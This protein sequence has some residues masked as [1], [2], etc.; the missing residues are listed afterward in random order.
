MEKH[1]NKFK[2]AVKNYK[3]KT[4]NICNMDEKGFLMELASKAKVICRQGRRNSRYTCDGSRELITVLECVSAEKHLLPSMIVTK[5]AH[6]YSDNYVRGQGM[7]GSVYGHSPKG[8]TTNELGLEW[9]EKHYELL[10][11]LEYNLTLLL[12]IYSI[13]ANRR[14]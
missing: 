13:V 8:W 7:P 11:H 6:H 5:G 9:I 1:L 14:S 12:T 10:T 2:K 3:V 4:D